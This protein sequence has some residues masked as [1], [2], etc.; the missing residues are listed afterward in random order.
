MPPNVKISG[1]GNTKGMFSLGSCGAYL[2]TFLLCLFHTQS[3]YWISPK[4]FLLQAPQMV[5]SL[6]PLWRGHFFLPQVWACGCAQFGEWGTSQ[7][8]QVPESRDLKHK[9]L[10][11]KLW[12]ASFGHPLLWV[13]QLI[14]NAST[15]W[16][17]WQGA[18]MQWEV[19][20]G[21]LAGK[22]FLIY[23]YTWLLWWCPFVIL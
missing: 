10:Q 20:E 17:L 22:L 7:A 6:S 2:S 3:S 8:E 13:V 1:A 16:Q 4:V 9:W 18:V 19:R 14:S 15:S 23:K 11:G 12:V 21:S 5:P